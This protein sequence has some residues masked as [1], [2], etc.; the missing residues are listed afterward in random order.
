ML[1]PTAS[2]LSIIIIVFILILIAFV[3]FYFLSHMV[4]NKPAMP[5][6]R[7][8][9]LNF[10][11]IVNPI[12]GFMSTT[13]LQQ[14]L[15]TISSVRNSL[16]NPNFYEYQLDGNQEVIRDGG[17]NMY[18]WG[19][20]TDVWFEGSAQRVDYSNN[21]RVQTITRN[22]KRLD[23]VSLGY[24]TPLMYLC[25]SSNSCTMGFQK[26][27]D[28][29]AD[30]RGQV[31]MNHIYSG[32]LVNGL[33]VYAWRRMV[34][35]T[36]TPSICDLCFAIGDDTST[37][38]S[39]TANVAGHNN[40]NSGYFGFSMQVTHVLMGVILLSKPHG[41]AVTVDECRDVINK[42]CKALHDTFM[43]AMISKNPEDSFKC[44]DCILAYQINDMN[45][46]PGK[47]AAMVDQ[48]LQVSPEEYLRMMGQ[49]M[50]S[51]PAELQRQL[52]AMDLNDIIGQME[53]FILI[54]GEGEFEPTDLC[55]VPLTMIDRMMKDSPSKVR[56]YNPPNEPESPMVKYLLIGNTL[57]L[58]NI[59]STYTNTVAD[60]MKMDPKND[61]MM[62]Y[63][64]LVSAIDQSDIR[65]ILVELFAH[66]DSKTMREINNLFNTY[67]V[68]FDQR[69]TAKRNEEISSM[70]LQ[71][72][73]TEL[74]K[75]TGERDA[76]LATEN[77]QRANTAQA[78][79]KYN[80]Q[81]N[82]LSGIKNQQTQ[83]LNTGWRWG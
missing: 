40:T 77:Q 63:G 51:L 53:K 30:N 33:R 22:G 3:V 4:C 62:A 71:E 75:D 39:Q 52:P 78:E 36:S 10:N 15:G 58:T 41:L 73:R 28:N 35:N 45:V 50:D 14:I 5:V 18:D 6:T 23:H 20:Y 46:D 61:A 65:T 83:R 7:E 57:L 44:K 37:F 47:A 26:L 48:I 81:V 82:R 60:L 56:F 38:H 16:K 55:L 27:G 69:Q 12:I 31:A 54:N 68:T 67:K 66:S 32:E 29:G 1:P 25:K 13:T 24:S 42:I 43:K 79:S 17:Q 59:K 34:F 80:T 72:A 2:L 64:A 21:T 49:S 8:R 9:Y 19:N 76:A 74:A 70:R 11:R